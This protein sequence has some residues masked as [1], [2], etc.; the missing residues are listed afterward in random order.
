MPVTNITRDDDGGN[1]TNQ[2]ADWNSAR[3]NASGTSLQTLPLIATSAI[4]YVR[5]IGGNR[6]I[7]RS[8]QKFDLSAITDGA[9]IDAAQ[10][11]IEVIIT[12]GSGFSMVAQESSYDTLSLDDFSDFTGPVLGTL[13]AGGAAGQQSLIL[14]ATGRA[15]LE[16]KVG[17]FAELCFRES[18][19]DYDNV[20]P[21]PGGYHRIITNFNNTPKSELVVT[22]N[23]PTTT[24]GNQGGNNQAGL[25]NEGFGGFGF[26]WG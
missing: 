1:I 17:G 2:Q 16:S 10:I 4:I 7:V 3:N 8:F 15:Y 11:N 24:A 20:D 12:T 18:G 9:I 21:L 23:L 26:G 25:I 22:W 14:N 5:E 19:Y 13:V 6:T